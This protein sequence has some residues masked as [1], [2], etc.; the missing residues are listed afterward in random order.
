MAACRARFRYDEDCDGNLILLEL[1]WLGGQIEQEASGDDSP[2][3]TWN[4]TSTGTAAASPWLA[5]P[6]SRAMGYSLRAQAAYSSLMSNHGIDPVAARAIN[7]L[8]QFAGK[9]I[10]ILVT[11][12]HR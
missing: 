7:L 3:R 4:R 6:T 12:L 10:P 1:L 5:F 9:G 11:P 8:H 2:R